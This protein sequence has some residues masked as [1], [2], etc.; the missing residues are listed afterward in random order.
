MLR[1]YRVGVPSKGKTSPYDEDFSLSLWFN[2]WNTSDFFGI[3][4]FFDHKYRE[5]WTL[6]LCNSAKDNTKM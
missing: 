1:S 2:Y 3:C 5:L 6:F 4:S